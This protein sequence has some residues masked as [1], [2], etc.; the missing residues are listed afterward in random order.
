[1]ISVVFYNCT[2]KNVVK[3]DLEKAVSTYFN[4]NK[5]PG[6]AIKII[7]DGKT[8]WSSTRGFSDLENKIPMETDL[9]MNI[10][11]VSK[12][13]TTTAIL[14]LWEQGSINLHENINTYLPFEVINPNYL[15]TPI[16]IRQLLT[17][18]SSIK[19]NKHYFASYAC[20][21]PKISLSYWLK[22]YF[23]KK[24]V[25]FMIKKTIFIVG[26]RMRTINTLTLLL[27]F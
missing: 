25:S 18:T 27:A 21:D 26:N 3:E 22:N 8:F 19:D 13:I 4:T 6:L 7:T 23:Q 9:V 16:T 14:Q 1:M 11:S 20:G 2:P 12:T 10:A 5:P 17:H 15:N 24:V